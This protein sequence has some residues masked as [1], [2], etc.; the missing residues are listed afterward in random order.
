M[1][2]WFYTIAIPFNTINNPFFHRMFVKIGEF[3]KGLKPL[4]YHEMREIFLKKKVQET[5][6]VIEKYKE[7]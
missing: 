4:S 3:G 2:R 6:N 5:L 7:Q 1:S